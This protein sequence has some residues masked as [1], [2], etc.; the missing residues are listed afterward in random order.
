MWFTKR[1]QRTARKRASTVTKHYV[2]HKEAARTLVLARLRH[3]NSYYNFTYNRVSI[4]NQRRCWGSC[5][6]LKNLNFSYKLLL[7]PP[8]LADYIIVHE[9]CH[10]KEM[11]H[12]QA[13][14]DLVA[15]V[16]PDYKQCVRELKA[17]EHKGTSVAY[18]RAV[19]DRYLSRTITPAQPPSCEET[20]YRQ[21]CE[22]CGRSVVCS[23]SF[24]TNL[25]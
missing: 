3:F 19:Q 25:A 5:S 6:S 22:S 17:I 7:L 23:C 16:I 11:N 4:K 12:G 20:S 8:H 9:L 15:E 13:F 24:D 1:R 10:L 2:E 14:W 21:W 18:L